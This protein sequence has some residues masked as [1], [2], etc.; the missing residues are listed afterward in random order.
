M[1]CV[2]ASDNASKDKK[3]LEKE[4]E[5]LISTKDIGQKINAAFRALSKVKEHETQKLKVLQDEVIGK[6]KI[7]DKYREKISTKEIDATKAKLKFLDS[8]IESV[9]QIK[10]YHQEVKVQEG[11]ERAIK[12]R[13]D[14]LNGIVQEKN[15]RSTVEMKRTSELKTKLEE[16]NAEIRKRG[17][18]STL[19]KK[20]AEI[21]KQLTEPRKPKEVKPKAEVSEEE[22]ILKKE[23]ADLQSRVKDSDWYQSSMRDA[24]IKNYESRLDKRT[25]EL[26]RRLAE[27]DFSPSRKERKNFISPEIEAK[28]KEIADLKSQVN[29]AINKIAYENRTKVQ[30]AMDFANNFKRFAIFTSPRSILKLA[31][32]TTEIVMAKGFTE[33]AGFSL[34]GFPIINEIS[35][36]APTEAG[37][38]KDV[39]KE[40]S[41]YWDGLGGGGGESKDF[42]KLLLSGQFAK[43]NEFDFA[44][45]KKFEDHEVPNT[46]LG[47]PGRLHEAVKNPTRVANYNL[48]L[49]RY[50]SWAE[51]Q[52]LD[53][54]DSSVINQAEL[55]AFKLANRSIFKND[56]AVVQIYNRAVGMAKRS[57]NKVA[58][59]LGFALEQT[60]PIVKVPTNIIFQTFEYAFG[61]IPASL[62]LAKFA[63][64]GIDNITPEEADIFMRQ[65]KNGAV[66][67]GFMALG[68]MLKD[69][70][71][72]VYLKGEDKPDIEYGSMKI[73]DFTVPRLLMENPL[74]ACLQMGATMARY[75]ENHYDENADVYDR[76]AL[77]PKT[78][79]LVALG[80]ISEAPFVKQMGLATKILG[81]R[82]EITIAETYARPYIPSALQYW[83]DLSDLEE[84]IDW[85]DW[86]SITSNIIQP[87]ATQRVPENIFQSLALAIP[88]LRNTVPER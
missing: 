20:K 25:A 38:A 34:R 39:S 29:K 84:P 19:L 75:W 85:T 67:L 36:M 32:A 66:G 82:P 64:K 81:D 44:L 28:Q 40:M 49:E 4:K 35:K 13:Q 2:R 6:R 52:G 55:Y 58:Q 23:I 10:T 1:S 51:R 45:N 50:L 24:A 72:G 78:L 73:G 7:T 17:R 31:A 71:G 76:V 37:R 70:I 43:A 9:N 22:L 87:K 14:R 47:L 15:K 3:D 77:G 63:V 56:N 86:K 11:L 53:V 57:D 69:Q 62:K 5:V 33:F 83:A 79:A 88:Y 74:F 61:S 60:L 26:K 46:W 27:N 80:V 41:L 21:E 54:N 12:E 65:L 18:L 8:K 42:F 68:A 59:G 48:S 30:V 16:V